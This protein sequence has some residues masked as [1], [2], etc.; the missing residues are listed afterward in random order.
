MF[1][2]LRAMF[3]CICINILC[4]YRRGIILVITSA[5]VCLH[6]IKYLVSLFKALLGQFPVK[7]ATNPYLIFEQQ[8]NWKDYLFWI[9]WQSFPLKFSNTLRCIFFFPLKYVNNCDLYVSV[10]MSSW[11]TVFWFTVCSYFLMSFSI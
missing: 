1:K 4:C 6:L 9:Y 7:I 3:F 5:G 11:T 10:S 2:H 8:N